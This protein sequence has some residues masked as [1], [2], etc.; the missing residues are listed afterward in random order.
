M[1]KEFACALTHVRH[2]GYFLEKWIAHYGAIVGRENLYVVIDG[3]DWEPEVDLSGIKTEILRDAPRRRIQN[4]RFMAHEMSTR[5]NGLRKSYAHVI[6]GD[7]DEYVVIDPETGLNWPE[8]LHELGEDGYIFALGV[9]V[10]Q[11]REELDAVARDR[12]LL[13]QRRFGYVA[14]TYTKPFVISRW[15][16]WAGGAHRLLNRSVRIS[17]HFVLFHMALADRHLAEERLAARGGTA[18]HPSFVG[19]QTDRLNTIGDDGQSKER[20]AFPEACAIAHAHFPVEA[21][22]SPAKRP[23]KSSDPRAG[24]RGLPVGIPDRFFGLV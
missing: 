14:D 7:C 20:L 4:D 6:R 21:D 1:A 11:A 18:Q 5:A 3:D 19:H 12:P 2:E 16:N 23:R 17:R 10:V 13:G 8:A 15:N 24:E 22:G 9:D